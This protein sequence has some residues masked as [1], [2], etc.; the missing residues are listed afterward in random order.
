[1][2]SQID[3]IKKSWHGNISIDVLFLGS[4]KIYV[5]MNNTLDKSTEISKEYFDLIIIRKQRVIDHVFTGSVIL[6]VSLLYINFGA[7]LDVQVLKGLITRPVVSYTFVNKMYFILMLFYIP[8]SWHWFSLSICF[9]A[10]AKFCHRL[11]CI[12]R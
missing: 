5:E 11:F 2:G 7:A 12:S 9:Y 6:L 10:F 4:T 3:P 8:E 1:M